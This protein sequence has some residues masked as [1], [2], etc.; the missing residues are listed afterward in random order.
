MF[1]TI[2]P[3]T[4]VI[5]LKIASFSLLLSVTTSTT[6]LP[7]VNRV[8]LFDTPFLDAYTYK[9]YDLESSRP[10]RISVRFELE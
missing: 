2:L 9:E 6:L 7:I 10:E 8:V 1:I 3:D 5:E 4:E